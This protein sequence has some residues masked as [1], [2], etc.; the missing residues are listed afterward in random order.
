MV[1]DFEFGCDNVSKT[2][3]SS[4]LDCLQ[5]NLSPRKWNC[6]YA[7]THKWWASRM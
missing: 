3:V 5:N 4:R 7:H 2:V 6:M 1:K